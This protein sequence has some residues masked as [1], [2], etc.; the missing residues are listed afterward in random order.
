[1]KFRLFLT[2]LAA[3]SIAFTGCDKIKKALHRTP[4]EAVVV[5]TPTPTPAPTPTPVPKVTA[6]RSASVIVLCY[7]RF[8]DKAGGIYSIAPAEFEQQMQTVKDNG[9]TVI[10]MQDFLAWK[11]DEKEIPAKSAIITIDDGY[12]SSY[13]VA[14]PILKKFNYPFT[15]FV[16]VQFVGSGGKSVTWDQLAEMRDDGV[17]IGCHSYTH[18][19]LYGN[20]GPVSKQAAEEIK[21]IGYEAWLNKEIVESKAIIEKQLGIKVATFS[22]PYGLYQAKEREICDVIKKAGYEGAF[23]VYGQR[24]GFS[25]PYDQMGRYAVEVAKPQIFHNA[26]AMVGGGQ[27]GYSGISA[28]TPAIAQTSA[29]TMETDPAAGATV[30]E[31]KPLIKAV[32]SHMGA[33]DAGT[34]EMRVSGFGLVPARYD[35]A[36]KSVSFQVSQPLRDKEYTV[37]VSA[38]VGGKKTE[39]RWSFKFDPT[40]KQ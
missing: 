2:C 34:V 15:M 22:Y 29:S 23:T 21:R 3:A 27:T 31:S 38:K 33:I 36:T 9:F 39:A 30:S 7:H 20:K 18:Q 26:I 13:E 32:L 40:A 6:N 17:D 28:S 5:S 1:M 24:I 25:A 16:Y 11:R 37:I 4:K 14:W 35:D 10:S 19:S 12:V 8:E